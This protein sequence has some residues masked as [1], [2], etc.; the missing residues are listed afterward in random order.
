M[1]PK[2]KA[3]KAF[4]AYIRTRDCLET[5]GSSDFGV[6]YTCG[7]R[8]PYKQLQ[9]GHCISGRGN[10]VLLNEDLC[11]AQCAQCNIFKSGNYDIFIPKIIRE[12][13]LKWFEEHK[14]L[15]RIPIKRNWEEE[16]EKYFKKYQE[17]ICSKKLPF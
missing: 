4:S 7:K 5:T 10:Y 14:R 8:L 9:C 16:R 15:S 2:E 3:W 1:K 13:S 17:L 12:H 6:C 11:R